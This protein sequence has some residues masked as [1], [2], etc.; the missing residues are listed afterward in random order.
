VSQNGF[1]VDYKAAR[2]SNTGDEY[3]ELW[4]LRQAIRLLDS[5]SSLAA[6]S[7]EGLGFKEGTD[8]VWDGVDCCLYF[9]SDDAASAERIEIQQLKYSASKPNQPWTVARLT[10]GKSGKQTNSP[11]RR[12]AEAYKGLITLRESKPNNTIKIILLTNQPVASDVID[13]IESA[14]E[15]VPNTYT[16]A[17]KLGDSDLHRLVKASGLTPLQFSDFAKTLDLQGASGFYM[18]GPVKRLYKC[19]SNI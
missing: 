9:G 10:T 13:L 16:R 1:D 6:V 18:R 3:H 12:L 19:T 15:N 7:V 11:I 4:A 8:S 5:E 17:W 14:Y 2:G